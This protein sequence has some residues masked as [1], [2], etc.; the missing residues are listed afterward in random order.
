MQHNRTTI[1]NTSQ[2]IADLAQAF[3]SFTAGVQLAEVGPWEDVVT[4]ATSLKL[5]GVQT[6]SATRPR[7]TRLCVGPRQRPPK[8]SS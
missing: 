4:L 2:D 3:N 7:R 8:T 1:Q 5:V 6:S